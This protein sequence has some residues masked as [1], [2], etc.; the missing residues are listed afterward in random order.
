MFEF[1]KKKKTAE[2]D[3]QNLPVHIGIIMDGNGRWAKRRAMPRSGGHRAGAETLRK[4][5]EFPDEIGI[6]YLT[7]YA[8]STENWAR[9]KE[10]VDALMKLL[11]EYLSKADEELYGKNSRI[12]VIG[13]RK[14]LPQDIQE[15]IRHTEEISAHKKGI[16]LN[17]AINYGGRDEIVHAVREIARRQTA[18]E[19]ITEELIHQN[20]YTDYMPDPDLIIRPSGEQRLSNFLLWQAAYSEFWYSDV[21]WPDFSEKDLL[22]AIRAYQNRDR[23]FGG[24]KA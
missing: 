12:R 18:P 14:G 2:I 13:N 21:R 5:T 4:I 19:K 7:V 9:P 17:L 3:Y 23:R 20:L 22:N 10:E 11:R 6:K 24:V 8:F 1:L 15:S 16:C